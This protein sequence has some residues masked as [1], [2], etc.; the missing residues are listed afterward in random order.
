MERTVC[1]VTDST[2][3]IPRDVAAELG[4]S[5]LELALADVTP[6]ALHIGPD[7][8]LDRVA[9]SSSPFVFRGNQGRGAN[10]PSGIHT[11]SIRLHISDGARCARRERER[12]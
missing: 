6:R 11:Q 12:S 9:H 8:H 7:V 5:R 10:I 2:S 1:V 3:D 4:R